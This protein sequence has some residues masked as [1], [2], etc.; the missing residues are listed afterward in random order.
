MERRF[1]GRNPS[2]PQ[3]SPKGRGRTGSGGKGDIQL[4]MKKTTRGEEEKI[5]KKAQK[6][7]Y[8]AY[9]KKE[10]SVSSLRD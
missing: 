10:E 2:I 7:L 4:L 3:S 5:N 8:P 1:C 9:L 6:F